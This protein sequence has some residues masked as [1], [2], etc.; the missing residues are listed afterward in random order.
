MA[1][2]EDSGQ[3]CELQQVRAISAF[4]GEDV[5]DLSFPQGELIE[6][7][8]KDGAGWAFGTIKDG[9]SGWFPLEHIE[10]VYDTAVA[11]VGIKTGEVNY[12]QKYFIIILI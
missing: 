4:N 3:P 1:K 10:L 7:S 8:R 9:S 11:E 5:T 6:I 2:Q 12:T